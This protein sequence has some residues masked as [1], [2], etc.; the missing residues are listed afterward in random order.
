MRVLGLLAASLIILQILLKLYLLFW[1]ARSSKK[2]DLAFIVTAYHLEWPVR[3]M[4]IQSQ[5]TSGQMSLIRIAVQT[6]P[7]V[8]SALAISVTII[9][10]NQIFGH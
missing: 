7:V 5:L 6:R 4:A 8:Y 10:V 1:V 9:L 3:S 2:W